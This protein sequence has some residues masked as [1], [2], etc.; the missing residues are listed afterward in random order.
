MVKLAEATRAEPIRADATRYE[1]TRG[2]PRRDEL[3]TTEDELM[4]WNVI[5]ITNPTSD[6]TYAIQDAVSGAIIAD[7]IPFESTARLMASAPRLL[8][9]MRQQLESLQ[10]VLREMPGRPGPG[11]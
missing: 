6:S 5:K 11:Q 3:F 8:A 1:P 2:D 10:Q 4:L 7:D 9:M